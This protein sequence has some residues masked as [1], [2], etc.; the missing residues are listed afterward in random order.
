MGRAAIKFTFTGCLKSQKDYNELVRRWPSLYIIVSPLATLA[1]KLRVV[2]D[3]GLKTG[4]VRCRHAA[5]GG[6]GWGGAGWGCHG[7]NVAP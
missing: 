2:G 5:G 1:F 6:G 3:T 7:T 4:W